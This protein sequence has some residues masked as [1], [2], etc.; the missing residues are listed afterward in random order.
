MERDEEIESGFET[1]R[2][3]ATWDKGCEESPPL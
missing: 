2:M 1:L 3:D